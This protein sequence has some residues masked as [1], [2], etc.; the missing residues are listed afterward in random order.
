VG[1]FRH[2]ALFYDG[3]RDFLARVAP[4]VR[5]GVEAEDAVLVVLPEPRLGALK[6][7]LRADIG[8]AAADVTFADMATIGRNPGRILSVWDQFVR[9]RPG[10]SRRARC[11]GEPIW[12]GR[13]PDEIVECEIHERLVDRALGDFPLHLMCPYD[14]AALPSD[15]VARAAETHE[16]GDRDED[17]LGAPMRPTPEGAHV[18]PFGALD[19]RSLRAAF[20]GLAAYVGLPPVRTDDL[21]LAVDEVATNS[22]RHGGGS[23]TLRTWIDGDALVCEITDSG[24]IRD[25]LVGRRRPTLDSLGGHGLWLVHQLCDL[26]QIRSDADGSVVRMRIDAGRIRSGAFASSREVGDGLDARP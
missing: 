12:S 7:E 22:V 2:E 23:G 3:Q 1:G 19:L 20:A 9:D 4:F 21:V 5:E 6:T 11:V 14:T 16:N 18:V 24:H 15:V 17:G 13:S 8:T 26:V 25:P 10:A